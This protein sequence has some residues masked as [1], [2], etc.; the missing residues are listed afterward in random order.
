MVFARRCS[1]CGSFGQRIPA[2]I[3]LVRF[4]LLVSNA[5]RRLAESTCSKREEAESVLSDFR[6]AGEDGEGD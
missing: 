2:N 4:E 5:A 3:N 1:S 6:G